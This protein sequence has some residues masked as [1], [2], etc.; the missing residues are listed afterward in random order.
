MDLGQMSVN[1]EILL[2]ERCPPPFD[3]VQ[4]LEIAP[5]GRVYP[6]CAEVEGKGQEV[7]YDFDRAAL[8]SAGVS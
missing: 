4:K 6:S 8:V 1:T 5:D 3:V 2:A 7:R